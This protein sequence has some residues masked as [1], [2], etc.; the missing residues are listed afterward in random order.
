MASEDLEPIALGLAKKFGF[1]SKKI[2]WDFFSP[3]GKSVRYENWKK[4]TSSPYFT[5]YGLSSGVPEYL[6]LSQKGRKLMGVDSITQTSEIYL[7]HD[8]L[9]MRFYI[10]TLKEGFIQQAYS[11]GELKMDRGLSIKNLGDGVVSKLPDL[12][13]DLKNENDFFRCALE[14]ERTRKSGGRY[15][16]MRRAYQRATKID[17]I[18]FGVDSEKI[19]SIITHE[20]NERGQN[21]TGKEIGFFDLF[22]FQEQGL[23]CELRISG[24]VSTLKKYFHS[25]SLLDPKTPENN[26]KVSDENLR[27]L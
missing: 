19:E 26:R 2:I 8:E 11:E 17:L 22:N 23:D 21:S 7:A 9:V 18:L 5:S 27:F 3:T 14:I 12:L 1:I 20:F 4:L 25:L 16:T 6:S 24:K 15:T 13:F 10:M